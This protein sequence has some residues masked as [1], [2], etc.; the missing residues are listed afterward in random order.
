[1]ERLDIYTMIPPSE[2]PTLTM[3]ETVIKIMAELLSTVALA[4]KQVM[5][6]QLGKPVFD[7]AALDS[8][9]CRTI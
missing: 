3:T 6:G 5:Q 2:A 4:T 8:T 7:D 1:M 9:R